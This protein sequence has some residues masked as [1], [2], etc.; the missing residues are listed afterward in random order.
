MMEKINILYRDEYVLVVYKPAGIRSEGTTEND[1]PA[2]LQAQCG[3]EIYPVHRLDRETEGCIVYARTQEAAKR[4]SA[5]IT[6]NEMHKE[7]LAVIAGQPEEDSAVLCDLLYHDVQKNKSYVVKRE[8]RGVRKAELSYTTLSVNKAEGGTCSLL[9][10]TLHTGRTHQ[11]RVQF[12]SRRH[13]LFGDTRY[14][15]FEREIP[16]A[17]LARTLSFPHPMRKGETVRVT[18]PVPQRYP[19]TLFEI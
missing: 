19:W 2:I 4:L 9:S 1:L 3:G 16:L 15:S 12:A 18:S 10:V 11:I 17:L 8:R 6:R 5:A 7:Y 14:G 13:P